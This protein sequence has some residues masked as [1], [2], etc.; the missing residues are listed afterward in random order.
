MV[1]N[2]PK[3]VYQVDRDSDFETSSYLWSDSVPW[4]LCPTASQ[5][6]NRYLMVVFCF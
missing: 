6:F 3:G 4:F 1:Y 2:L 5:R